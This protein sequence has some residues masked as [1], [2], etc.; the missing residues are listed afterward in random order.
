MNNVCKSKLKL[1]AISIAVLGTFLVASAQAD[2]EELRALT[3]PQSS[4]QVEAIIVDGASAKF[5]EYNG[6]NRGGGYANG[7]LNIRGGSAYTGNQQG[8][9]NRW[10][11]TGENLGLTSRSAGVEAS[12]Q[13]N[14]NLGLYYDQ[15]QHNITG[16]YQT[17]YTGTMGGNRFTLPS[18]LQG[19][20]YLA[21]TAASYNTVAGDLNNLQ[22][23]SS[24]FNTT[25]KGG[26]VVN[27]NVDISFEYNNLIQNGAKLQAFAGNGVANTSGA[28]ANNYG[29]ISTLPNPTNY[30]TDTLNLAVNWKGESSHLTASYFGSFFQD[31]YSNVT[32]QAFNKAVATAPAVNVTPYQTM[33]TA[34]SNAFNQ[35][36]LSG[37]YDFS[38]KT[39][40]NG[41]LS[42]GRNTQNQNFA[43]GYD[44]GMVA[45]GFPV[46]ASMNGLVNTS[47]AD[48]KLTDQSIKDLTLA[49]SAKFDERD[50]LTQSNMYSFYGIGS[51]GTSS[52]NG[53]VPN[54]PMSIKQTQLSLSADYR[55]TK[56]QKISASLAN[57]QINRWC[58]QFGQPGSTVLPSSAA[59]SY[60]FSGTYS[61][62]YNSSSCVSA[63]AS[64]ESKADLAYKLKAT[65]DLNL[66]FNAGY[67]NRK[68]S[69]DQQ[70]VVAMPFGTEVNYGFNTAPGY[71]SGNVI[72]FQ[73]FFEA[74]R[75]QFSGKANA[76]WQATDLL[77]FN[78]SGRYASDIYPD[79]RWGVQ[80]GN[81]WSLNLDS[82]Y[83]Y[84]DEGT[85]N[86]Y[87]TQQNQQRNLASVSGTNTSGVPT[88]SWTNNQ[89]NIATTLGV[90]LK[91]GGLV[92]GKVT[93]MAD[94]IY[95]TAKTYY[96]SIATPVSANA[97]MYPAITNNMGAIKLGANYALDKNS[98]LGFQYWYQHLYSSD[99]YYN[100][101]QNGYYTTGVMPTNQ[102][103]PSYNINVFSVAY[104]YTFD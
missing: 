59:S 103:A 86:A 56:D 16:T 17:P 21:N 58:N 90:G 30:Q 98:K 89:Q 19:T 101:Y 32:W 72:G 75:Q 83:L 7:A 77:A 40:L 44:T 41:N 4:V 24:R 50:N 54:T 88:G 55:L 93:A 57:S 51:T 80:N 39:K 99:Y 94:L 35:L 60:N 46:A 47:H 43:G 52:Q 37:G 3:Q 5:G 49:A 48:L 104:T 70:A 76:N 34:P 62:F 91:Q 33:S 68:T 11:V 82:S 20:N 9:T 31:N 69:W 102:Q 74:S 45:T 36:N 65:D 71:N 53:V 2:E 87:V 6:L 84:T 27:P 97:G 12:D 22:V 10:S 42:F 95:S 25:A 63:T 18:N 38:T 15:L 67:S 26:V 1:S 13:G 100:L 81:L 73:P 29:A 23:S 66:K 78:L 96:N 79:S 92:G 64:N 28:T 61:S 14:W 8:D 85:L